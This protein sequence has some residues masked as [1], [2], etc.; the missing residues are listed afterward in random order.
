MIKFTTVDEYIASFPLETRPKLQQLRKTIMKAAPKAEESISYN[1]PTYKQNG[2]LV[3]FA[4]YK[5]HIGLYP[6]IAAFKKELDKYEGGKGTVK[7]PLD[8]PIPA[9]LV[10]D[11]VKHQVKQ[12]SK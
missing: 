12:N 2:R 7:F 1:M 8:K 6:R 3:Y 4:G 5:S 11:M 9:K 10:A